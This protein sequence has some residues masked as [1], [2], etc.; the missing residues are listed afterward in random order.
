[1][2][3]SGDWQGE[4]LCSI[5]SFRNPRKWRFCH[6]QRHDFHCLLGWRWRYPVNR[7]KSREAGERH[8]CFL[9]TLTQKRKTGISFAHILF[10]RTTHMA[11]PKCKGNL[12]IQILAKRP[13]PGTNCIKKK[14]WTSMWSPCFHTC[15]PYY[16]PFS[17]QHLECDL[18]NTISL[19]K[20]PA[21]NLIDL[22]EHRIQCQLLIK[23]VTEWFSGPRLTL[24]SDMLSLSLVPHILTTLHFFQTHFHPRNYAITVSFALV[25]L[26]E[27]LHIRLVIIEVAGPMSNP[28]RSLS[29]P[30]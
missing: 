4:G 8:I 10:M 11:T 14:E 7:W 3:I 12:E 20:S 9:I 26:P 30:S 27:D 18:K 25:D 28:N 17:V 22:L 29:W 1:M 23:T 5:L 16:C 2:D 21:Y 19:F 6:F 15:S 13:L 24:W